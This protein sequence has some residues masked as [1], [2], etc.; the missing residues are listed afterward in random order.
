[1]NNTTDAVEAVMAQGPAE[2]IEGEDDE[3][4]K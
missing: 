3:M 1:L 2:S 4:T